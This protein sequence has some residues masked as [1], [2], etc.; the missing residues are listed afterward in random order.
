MFIKSIII[1][2]TVLKDRIVT[3]FYSDTKTEVI[4]S[5]L[6][7]LFNKHLIPIRPDRKFERHKDKCCKLP[8]KQYTS[9]VEFFLDILLLLL[10]DVEKRAGK[11]LALAWACY[12]FF[13]ITGD[14]PPNES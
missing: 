2:H 10:S 5:E 1:Y 14:K 8:R 11:V 6:K 4:F 7:E 12:P 9:K 3:L 13:H